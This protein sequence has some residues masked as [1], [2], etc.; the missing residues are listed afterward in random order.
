MQ[1]RSEPKMEDAWAMRFWNVEIVFE[2]VVDNVG[3]LQLAERF[4]AIVY[5]R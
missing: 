3:A 1:A 2:R 5:S 4:L